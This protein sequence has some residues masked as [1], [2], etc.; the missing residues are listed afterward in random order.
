M[1]QIAISIQILGIVATLLEA[2]VIFINWKGVLHG[3]SRQ[4]R[5][6]GSHQAPGG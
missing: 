1:Y 2:W 6:S 4:C 5:G 3:D